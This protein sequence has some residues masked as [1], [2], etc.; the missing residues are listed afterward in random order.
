MI[1]GIVN[2][3]TTL[4]STACGLNKHRIYK[5]CYKYIYLMIKDRIYIAF[6]GYNI[7]FLFK[8]KS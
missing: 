6:A 8:Y 5:M 1:N 7:L 3:T 4:L 2:L